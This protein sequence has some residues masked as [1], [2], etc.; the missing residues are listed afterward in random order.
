MPGD[1]NMTKKPTVRSSR[2]DAR[3]CRHTDR[4]ARPTHRS[5]D[6]TA[7]LRKGSPMKLSRRS[8]RCQRNRAISRMSLCVYLM[9]PLNRSALLSDIGMTPALKHAP[10]AKSTRFRISPD[11][12]RG[13]DLLR[14]P[15]RLRL[16]PA[17]A[18]ISKMNT[19][20]SRQSYYADLFFTGQFNHQLWLDVPAIDLQPLPKYLIGLAFRLASLAH[21]GPRG[22]VEVV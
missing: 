5:E 11:V 20:T 2:S 15:A 4:R 12:E 8:D 14:G 22:C 13:L 9:Q 18:R 7:T 10:P 6:S 21:A 1:P 16:E 17:R 19:R 3:R